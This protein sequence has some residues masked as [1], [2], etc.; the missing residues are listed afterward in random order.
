MIENISALV[1]G[2]VAAGAFFGVACWIARHVELESMKRSGRIRGDE[3][4]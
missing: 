3:D 2:M 4:D 1:V